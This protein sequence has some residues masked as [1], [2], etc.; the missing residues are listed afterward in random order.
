MTQTAHLKPEPFILPGGPTGIVLVHGYTGSPV[1]MRLMGEYL[2]ARGITV[3]APLLPGHG[4]DVTDMNRRHWPEWN[5]AVEA[6][7]ADLR[8]RCSSL[9]V[10][11]LSM[12]SLLA[13]YAAACH[14]ELAGVVTYSP[15]IRSTDWRIYLTPVARFFMKPQRKS[16]ASDLD[17]PAALQR[18]WSYDYDAPAAAYE[19][20]K[21]QFKVRSLLPSIKC[22]LLVIYSPRDSAIHP[23]AGQYVYD[24]AGSADKQVLI[25]QR[26]GHVITVDSEWETVAERTYQFIVQHARS[27]LTESKQA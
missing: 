5:A 19:T 26:S 15:A 13:L 16:G 4:T 25:L 14:P 23:Q 12:G 3:C 11:G 17:D 8:P 9:F 2:N 20:L 10:G 1:E 7:L 27:D 6:A 22:P 24:H 21:L 18:I